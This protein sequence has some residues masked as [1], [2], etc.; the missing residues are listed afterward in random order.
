MKKEIVA[1]HENGF[2]VSGF[3]TQFAMAKSTIC[4]II[5]INKEMIHGA[6]VAIEIIVH[7]KQRSQSIEEVEKLLL[8]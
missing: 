4:I 5:L 1:K 2:H 8:I 6:N 3:A 7:T